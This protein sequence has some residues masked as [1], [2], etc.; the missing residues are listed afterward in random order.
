MNSNEKNLEK[1]IDDLCITYRNIIKNHDLSIEFDDNLSNNFFNWNYQDLLNIHN[2]K[3]K[4]NICLKTISKN[5]LINNDEL[6]THKLRPSLDLAICFF[7]FHD[8]IIYQQSLEIFCNEFSYKYVD[9][10]NN[11]ERSRII[12]LSNDLYFGITKNIFK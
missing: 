2:D 5:F 6:I 10:F 8:P 11:L 4:I 7:K 12:A 1:I 3:E 9:L